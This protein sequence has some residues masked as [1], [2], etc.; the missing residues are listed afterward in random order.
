MVKL[1]VSIMLMWFA[2]VQTAHA[3]VSAELNQYIVP[4]GESVQLTITAVGDTDGDPD[5]SQ[6]KQSF[7]ILGQSQSS[8]YS[9]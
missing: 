5:I 4:Y 3:E 7:D 8:N 2:I 1:S 9:F 6:L